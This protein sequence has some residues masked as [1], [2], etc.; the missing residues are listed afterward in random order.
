MN[1]LIS[2]EG[3]TKHFSV[4]GTRSANKKSV[5][6]AVEN[7]TFGLGAGETLALVGETG[8]GKS[9]VARLLVGLLRP[10]TGRVLY[11]GVDL[12]SFS[13]GEMRKVRREIQMVFQDPYASLNP[14]RTA[15]QLVAEA[16]KIHPGMV[17]KQERSARADQLLSRVGFPPSHGNRY[18]RQLSGGQRQRVGIARALAIEPRVLIFDEPVASL[19][20]SVQAQ[21]LNLIADLQRDLGIAYV[22]IAH[23]LAAV[24]YVASKV[25]VM[26]LG[27]IVEQ[28][29]L[30]EIFNSPRHPYTQALLSAVPDPEPWQT[31]KL[32]NIVLEGDV[33]SPTNP[34]S[35]CSFRTRC[36]K[37]A[38]VCSVTEPALEVRGE[39]SPVA[40]HFPVPMQI[41][42]TD[43]ERNS[44]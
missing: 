32:V 26:Y 42:R 12:S 17:P 29:S 22:F 1:D 33:P 9:T 43:A 24:R 6:K 41:Y 2:V 34:P 4:R 10:T 15:R 31:R 8:C 3:L 14:R 18:P 36:W 21:V 13:A 28:G 5:I 27:K 7:V 11:N 30:D 38:E 40:C 35:G 20:V 16:W 19:D 23:D 37:A 25:A 44:P 39:G